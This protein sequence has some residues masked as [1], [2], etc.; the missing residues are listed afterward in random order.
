MNVNEHVEQLAH[1]FGC[2]LNC[3][4]DVM[5]QVCNV[6]DDIRQIILE[7]YICRCVRECKHPILDAKDEIL[8]FN[9]VSFRKFNSNLK[10]ELG[11]ARIDCQLKIIANILSMSYFNKTYFEMISIFLN[12]IGFR[13]TLRMIKKLRL[14][15]PNNE[16][17]KVCFN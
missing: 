15:F 17:L 5:S 14:Y 12:Q 1:V 9:N 10:T 4:K 11:R 7:K 16:I 3:N 13:P 6:G 8:N 2:N